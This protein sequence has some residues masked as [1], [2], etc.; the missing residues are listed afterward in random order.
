MG[1]A[2][3]FMTI[4]IALVDAQVNA[5]GEKVQ[6]TGIEAIALLIFRCAFQ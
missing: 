2:F 1:A 4:I 3:L 6:N 5:S